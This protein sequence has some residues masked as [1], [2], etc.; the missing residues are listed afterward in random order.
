MSVAESR[1]FTLQFCPVFSCVKSLGNAGNS[2][3]V[4]TSGDENAI[5]ESA[6]SLIRADNITLQQASVG[7]NLRV[8]DAF[9]V[10][11]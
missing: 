1:D 8:L 2:A 10:R 4:I 11:S 9:E 7:L 5:R 3:L 6:D